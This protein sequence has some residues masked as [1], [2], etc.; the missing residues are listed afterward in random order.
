DTRGHVAYR[1]ALQTRGQHIRREKATSNICTAQVL[2]A[3]M[4]SVFAVYHA[5]D[6]LHAIAARVHEH[7][8]A[9]AAGAHERGIPVLKADFFDTVALGVEG[10]AEELRAALAERRIN[11][12]V[13]NP[14]TVQIATDELTTGEIVAEVLEVLSGFASTRGNEP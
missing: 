10:R 5:T 2:L 9:V 6:G 8:R 13:A 4:A 1:L 3:V 12:H 11:I 14:D 7:A